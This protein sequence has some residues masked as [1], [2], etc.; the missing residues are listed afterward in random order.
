MLRIVCVLLFV[1]LTTLAGGI[2]ACRA[3]IST[4]ELR[5]ALANYLSCFRLELVGIERQRPAITSRNFCLTEVYDKQ[6]PHPFWVTPSGPGEKARIVLDFLK[7]CEAEGL[8][9][10]NYEVNQIAALFAEREPVSLARLDT[11]LTYNLVKYIHDVRNGPIRPRLADPGLFPEAGD[12]DFNPATSLEAALSAPDLGAFLEGLPPAH[13]HYI[14]LKRALMMYRAIQMQGGWPLISPGPT[15]EPGASDVR[16]PDIIRRLSA[17]GDIDPMTLRGALPAQY[18]PQFEQAVVRFQKRHG[19]EADGIIGKQTLAAMNVPVAERIKQIIINMTRWRWHER[20]LGNKYILVNIAHFDLSVIDS[21]EHIFNCAVIVGK[22]KQQTPVFSERIKYIDINPFWNVPPSIARNEDLPELRKDP[23][24]LTRRNI[25]L[26]SSWEDG[27]PEIDPTT[28]DWHAVSPNQMGRY[29]LRQ[30]PG[31]WNALGQLKFVFPNKYK[32]YLHDTPTQKLFARQ[33]RS[34]S[35]GCIRVSEPEKLAAIVLAGQDGG[36]WTVEKIH[37][38]IDTNKRL[39]IKLAEP[40]PIHITYQTSWID[41]HGIVC[42][43]YDVYGR[44]AKLL[45]ALSKY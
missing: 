15:I 24:T 1:L 7:R 14:G 35:H 21:E 22:L 23:G 16:I 9:P 44:D 28:I 36:S 13:R 6:N 5:R 40:L 30:H 20:D 2:R 38:S 3:E 34:F 17:T 29:L 8:E 43:N 27:A 39:I 37:N 25:R 32:V 12:I 10:G 18:S 31:P 26:F 4:L 33:T 42:F 19:L 41:K 45:K 11:L